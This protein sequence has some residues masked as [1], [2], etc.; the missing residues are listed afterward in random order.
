MGPDQSDR[1]RGRFDH[2]G[3]RPLMEAHFDGPPL[4]SDDMRG[5]LMHDGMRGPIMHPD[6][7]MCPDDMRGP[8]PMFLDPMD[9]PRMRFGPRGMMG[10]M[11]RGLM[12]PHGPGPGL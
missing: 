8:G 6:E 1:N 11:P 2:S 10:P 3:P 4:I 7:L 12:G 5:P 9:D